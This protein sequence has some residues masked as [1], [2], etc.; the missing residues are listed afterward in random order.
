[1]SRVQ[2]LH[3]CNNK[4][5]GQHLYSPP[6]N[7]Y[8]FDNGFNS[9]IRG[10]GIGILSNSKVFPGVLQL[11]NESGANGPL[12]VDNTDQGVMVELNR[13]YQGE[14]TRYLLSQRMY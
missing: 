8:S 3:D 5:Y 12:W 11:G 13:R 10:S 7:V 9:H 4:W 14:N 6:C 2:S 1:M